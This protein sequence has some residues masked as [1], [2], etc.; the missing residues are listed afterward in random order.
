VYIPGTKPSFL[1]L[2]FLRCMLP[3]AAVLSLADKTGLESIGI[4]G[5]VTVTVA[6]AVVVPVGTVSTTSASRA[7][8][9]FRGVV[10]TVGVEGLGIALLLLLVRRNRR[11][12]L[13]DERT[14][15]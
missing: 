10:S 9:V 5:V 13:V 7:V 11:L 8:S 2:L 3:R 6:V 15:A 1:S 12:E 14:E 4:R